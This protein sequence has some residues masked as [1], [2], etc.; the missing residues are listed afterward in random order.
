M[1]MKAEQLKKMFKNKEKLITLRVN[2]AFLDLLDKAIE[3][4]EAFDSRSEL[5]ETLILRYL[6]ERGAIK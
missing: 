1:K 6:E 3:K 4:D 5:I 2:P